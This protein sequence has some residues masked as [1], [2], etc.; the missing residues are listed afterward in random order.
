MKKLYELGPSSE[1][2]EPSDIPHVPT[3]VSE[4]GEREPPTMAEFKAGLPR[5]EW[6]YGTDGT[7]ET[8]GTGEE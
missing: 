1:V 2:A 4:R 7:T 6:T 3:S 8:D 5:I